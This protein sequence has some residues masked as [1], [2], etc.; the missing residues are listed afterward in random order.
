MMIDLLCVTLSKPLSASPLAGGS[1][2]SYIGNGLGFWVTRKLHGCP[3]DISYDM[4]RLE[5][6]H[7]DAVQETPD[8]K[9][10]PQATVV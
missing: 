4:I 9:Y 10:C 1:S 5:L 7:H 8:R 6:D 2:P 3:Y